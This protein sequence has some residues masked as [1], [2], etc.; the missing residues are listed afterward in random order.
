MSLPLAGRDG[1]GNPTVLE[2]PTP[3]PSPQGG[4]D[5]SD[6]ASA[7]PIP[8]APSGR[9][10]R[11]VHDAWVK[12]DADIGTLPDGPVI[13]PKKR[14][15][16]ERDQLAGRSAPLGLLISAGETVDDIADDLARFALIALDFPKFS[17]GRA[18]STARL[19][20]EKHGYAGELRAVGNVLA[21]QIPLMRRVGFDYLR[22]DERP[23]PPRPGRGSSRRSD[24][25]L[26]ACRHRRAARRHAAV[27]QAHAVG[28]NREAHSAVPIGA[29]EG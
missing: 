4:G 24:A 16:A 23:D 5:R 21:D 9:T 25:P 8:P 22:G 3:Y 12:A 7:S 26:P 14:W 27:A 19:L 1:G 13:V 6:G 18:F 29:W 15:L 20:R 11:F 28:R 2:S 10:A 17:D